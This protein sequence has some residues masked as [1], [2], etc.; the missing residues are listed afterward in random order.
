MRTSRVLLTAAALVLPLV[1]GAAAPATLAASGANVS[2]ADM[3]FSPGHVTVGLGESVTWTFKD[4]IAHRPISDDGFFDTGA[5]SGGATRS[6]RFPSAGGFPYHCM[7]HPMMVGKVTVP[8]AATGSVSD[9][10]KL[11]WLA[12]TNPKGRSYDV[13]VRRKGTSAWTSFRKGTT[14][15]TG[16]FDPGKGTWQARART[17]KGSHKSR[18][19]PVLALP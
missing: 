16:R 15:G 5:A 3:A 10:W 11:R 12:G 14:T 13:Q 17:L 7:I 4:A 2:V 1:A 18:W 6:V 9:G 19:S 8:M